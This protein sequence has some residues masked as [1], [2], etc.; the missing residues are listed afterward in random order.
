M[1][2]MTKCNL[3]INTH[4]SRVEILEDISDELRYIGKDGNELEVKSIVPEKAKYIKF[5]SDNGFDWMTGRS[6][7]F[8]SVLLLKSGAKLEVEN[9]EEAEDSETDRR[10]ERRH[11]RRSV[12]PTGRG[13]GI[14]V[15]FVILSETRSYYG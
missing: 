13:Y 12:R 11:R 10:G 14:R 15:V 8:S 4:Y 5:T 6:G 1:V 9:S 7:E 2:V 3:C